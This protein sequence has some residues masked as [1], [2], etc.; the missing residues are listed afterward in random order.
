[1]VSVFDSTLYISTLLDLMDK[2]HLAQYL[3]RK[4]W[5]AAKTPEDVLELL[6]AE[7]IREHLLRC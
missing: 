1:M 6:E 4:G 2:E 3:N 7:D 5:I